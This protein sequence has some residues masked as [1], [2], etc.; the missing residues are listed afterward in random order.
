MTVTY[1]KRAAP[2]PTT[3]SA[4]LRDT[5]SIMLAEIEHRGEEAARRY[6]RTLDRWEGEIVL[7]DAARAEAVSRVPEAVKDTIRFAQD[8]IRRFAEAQR[9]TLSDCALELMPGHWVGQ[10]QIPVSAVGCYVPG[11]GTAMSP[12]R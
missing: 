1:L 3:E 9:A 10:R 7:S 11:G 8:N 6:G 12:A 5:V 4:D 2:R